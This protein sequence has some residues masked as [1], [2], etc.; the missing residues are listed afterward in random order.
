MWWVAQ[1]GNHLP[2]VTLSD[3]SYS[4]RG[5]GGHYIV[6]IPDMDVVVVHRVNTDIGKSVSSYEFG[7]LLTY[8]L[9]AKN[10]R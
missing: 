8:I 3:G 7:K 1:N 4:A 5:A 2:N 9:D 10:N 6:L